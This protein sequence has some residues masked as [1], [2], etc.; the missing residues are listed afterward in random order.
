MNGILRNESTGFPG[1]N[2][3]KICLISLY[4]ASNI[5]LRY[6][7][8]ALQQPGFDVSVI[9]FKEKNI[10]LDL[11]EEPTEGDYKA[12][13]D[14]ISELNPNLVGIGVRSSFLAIASKISKRIQERFGKPV[15]WGGTHATVA[16][17]QSIQI[18]DMICLGEGEQ[19]IVELAQK[20][21]GDENTL[22]INNLW[23]KQNGQITKNPIR[24][25]L[26]DVD[27]MPF[28]DYGSTN[29]Y[30]VEYG[31][32]LSEDPGL[33][34]FNLDI[35]TSRGCP[36]HCTYCCN[37]SFRE[38]YKGK[39]PLV[40]QRSVQ[41][42]LD[43]IQAH[44]ELFPNLKRIDFIDE[45]FS[46]DK[47]WV[48]EFVELYKKDIA[49]PFHCMQHPNTVGKEVMRMLKDAGLERVEIGI[50]TG[51]ER[52]RK[53]IFK[54]PVS[55]RKLIETSKI[56]RDL[57]IVPFY[58][59]I[60]DNPFETPEDKKQGLNFLL[61]MSRPFYM[62]MFSLIYF[63]NTILTKNALEA[64]LISENDVEG[65]ITKSFD[66]M[67]V[68]LKHP[69]P[70]LDRFWI[71]LYSLTSKRFVP[72]ALITLLSSSKILQKHPGPLVT[73]ASLC[74]NIK[75]GLIALKW[76]LEGKPVF[77]ALAKRGKS[78]KKGTRII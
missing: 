4:S 25:L 19:T 35:M 38:L 49:L 54:R 26:E 29:K 70:P 46:W 28:P 1:N 13:T 5:G 11:M 45:V 47:A 67:Y 57:K 30:F 48:E 18:A 31:E 51:S 73:F 66:Q 16:P 58:D 63:P 32:I 71:S 40:R 60:V 43:E 50:Q 3:Y 41:N 20:L 75:L 77:A 62:H 24:P 64:K 42:V 74:N 21:S 14:L 56:M 55:D 10:A 78:K 65:H 23:I 22:D 68:S 8:S 15:I 76:L 59:I 69:R 37:S 17:E 9:F 6:L 52:V 44:R 2:N 34:A 36:Y 7:A 53:E 39:G 12:L 72:R 33:Q 27:S 61:K